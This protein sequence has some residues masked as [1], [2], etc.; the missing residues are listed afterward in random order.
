MPNQ[1]GVES[2]VSFLE[3]AHDPAIVADDQ[4][5]I[6]G[7]NQSA[8][9]LFGYRRL[10]LVGRPLRELVPTLHRTT[11]P[12]TADH[13]TIEARHADGHSMRLSVA[14]REVPVDHQLL[15]AAYFRPVGSP[16]SHDDAVATLDRLS[17]PVARFDLQ[18][19]LSYANLALVSAVGFKGA[20]LLGKTPA[21]FGLPDDV[22]LG[23]TEAIKA[24]ASTGVGRRFEFRLEA[25]AAQRCYSATAAPERDRTGAVGSVLVTLQNISDVRRALASLEAVELRFRRVTDSSQDLISEHTIDGHFLYASPAAHGILDRAPDD[26]AGR[27]LLEFVHQDDRN[28]VSH[29]LKEAAIRDASHLINFRLLKPDGSIVW[30]EMTANWTMTVPSSAPTITCITRDITER[31]RG[32]EILRGASRMEATATLAAGVAHD[33]NNLMT[34]ILGNAE[35]LLTDVTFPDAPSRLGQIAEAAKRGGA[36]AQQLLAYARGGKYQAQTVSVN[37][38]VQ[39]ALQLQK[40]AMPPRVLLE[41]NLDPDGPHIEADPV[42]IGQVITNLC[43][44][45]SEAI[46]GSGRVTVRTRQLTMAVADV[47][48]KP[49]L[50]PGPTVLIQVADSGKGIEPAVLPRIFEPFFSTKFQGR[51]L[52]LA[53]AYGIVK[54]HRGFIG[55]ES[56]PGRGTTFS[57]Y[58]PAVSGVAAVVGPPRDPFPTGQETV[59][60]VDD[61]EAVIEVTKSILER[62][63]YHVLVARH[64]IEAVEV[65]RT[66]DGPIDLVL[67]DMG[68]P[69]AGGAEAFPFLKAARPEMRILISSGYEMNEVVQGLLGAGAD[70]FL[71]KPY[72]VTALARG[73]RQVLDREVAGSRLDD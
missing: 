40:H 72:R 48:E 29:G 31:V 28:H 68:M 37:E 15:T 54:N 13:A 49:G 56:V 21:A 73:I 36:L 61:D 33:F 58:L 23:W 6:V 4:Q 9:S 2:L 20:D 35:L 27:S 14:F 19:R 18:G 22:G 64:G 34:A 57:I 59:L 32:E 50:A 10:D 42:Q 62:L 26:L 70:A 3:L 43:I 41:A 7:A 5:R 11:D 24:A 66:H 63:R 39:Q 1:P 52:G 47:A 51:G 25:R 38:V 53:A 71:Q 60:L 17:V 12:I 67:L 30:C 8:E 69:F 45:A 44:N 46:P 16:G 55:V 65:A